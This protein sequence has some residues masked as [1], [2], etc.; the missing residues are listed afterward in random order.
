MLSYNVWLRF[1][2]H[3]Q[4]AQVRRAYLFKSSLDLVAMHVA[5][6]QILL[7]HRFVVIDYL[8]TKVCYTEINAVRTKSCLVGILADTPGGVEQ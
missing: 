8:P 1:S 6:L 3:P 5:K 7:S 4:I 2:N